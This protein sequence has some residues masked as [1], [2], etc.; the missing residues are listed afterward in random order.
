MRLL[1]F[2]GVINTVPGTVLVHRPET[3]QGH[4][5]AIDN[6]REA[7]AEAIVSRGERQ[8]EEERQ[9]KNDKYC[10]VYG[11]IVDLNPCNEVVLPQRYGPIFLGDCAPGD[12]TIEFKLDEAGVESLRRLNESVMTVQQALEARRII[13]EVAAE[14]AA[15]QEG[16]E[17]LQVIIVEKNSML[18]NEYPYCEDCNGYGVCVGECVV[19]D[20]DLDGFYLD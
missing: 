12:C 6:L 19:P 17:I 11:G 20:I 4:D 5:H 13:A 3:L 1:E 7:L 15:K 8:L 16:L 18:P 14:E 9:A 10:R 2:P